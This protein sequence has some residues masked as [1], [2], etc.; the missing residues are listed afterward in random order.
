MMSTGMHVWFAA[1]VGQHQAQWSLGWVGAMGV[2]D[3][4]RQIEQLRRLVS[5]SGKG[6]KDASRETRFAGANTS[7]KPKSRCILRDAHDLPS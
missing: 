7:K 5:V 4:D 6:G 2:S 1:Q 3:L